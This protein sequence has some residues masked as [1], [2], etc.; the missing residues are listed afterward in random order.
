MGWLRLVESIKLDVSFAEYRLFCRALLQKRP[1][2]LSILLTKVTSY[3]MGLRHSMQN[4]AKI[5]RMPHFY[6]S[7]SAKEPYHCPQKSPRIG[8]SFAEIDPRDMALYGT[9]LHKPAR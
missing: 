6:R 7:L 8:G 1:T 2:I 5:R 9:A 3:P 4:F